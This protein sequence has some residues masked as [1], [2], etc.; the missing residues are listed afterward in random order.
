[1][2]EYGDTSPAG[3]AR[4]LASLGMRDRDLFDLI[5]E[6]ER[7]MAAAEE[8]WAAAADEL[9]EVRY[10]ASHTADGRERSLNPAGQQELAAAERIE[11]RC[12]AGYVSARDRLN[13]LLAELDAS[14]L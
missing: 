11:H 2:S 4:F 7:S 13:D 10:R 9:R 8:D 3:R 14:H 6:A 1:M 12:R 5:A